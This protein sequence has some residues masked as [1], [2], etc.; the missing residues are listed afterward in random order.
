[1]KKI[2]SFKINK[3]ICRNK[4]QFITMN[5]SEM[6]TGQTTDEV[7][8]NFEPPTPNEESQEVQEVQNQ[9][10]F[11][12]GELKKFNLADAKIAELKEQYKDVTII[13]TNDKDGYKS[14]K[15]ALSVLRPIRTAIDKKRKELNEFPLQYQKAV[16]NEAKRLTELIEEIEKPIKERKD[17]IDGEKDRIKEAELKALEE[18]ANKRINELLT[19]GMKFEGEY[20]AIGDVNIS[21][22]DVRSMSDET[23]ATFLNAVKTEFKKTEDERL[24]KE[25]AD[26]LERERY[27]KEVAEQKAEKERLEKEKADLERQKTE[28][29]NRITDSRKNQ[30]ESIGMRYL[31]SERVFK[32]ENPLGVVTYNVDL[33]T[34]QTDAE[35]TQMFDG[36]KTQISDLVAKKQT[37]DAQAKE[38]AEKEAQE[39]AEKEAKDKAD[40]EEAE[41][42][43][44]LELA[45][46]LDKC[47]DAFD[48]IL[49][50]INA[51]KDLPIKDAE[52]K[53]S[54][55]DAINNI[56][57][58][59]NEYKNIFQN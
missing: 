59:I 57:L 9:E 12:K 39:K 21:V 36:L 1:M 34:L 10:E 27:E 46:D 43:R 16:N 55:F 58:A 3:Y 40:R 42:L 22:V 2:L 14:A 50:T 26:R 17:W 52:M 35:F 54:Y 13:D 45:P 53:K 48:S 56:E 11:L 30:L 41:R 29:Q 38:L 6:P 8:V 24:A 44:K 47:I 18:K 33:L 25:E 31:N 4:T 28:L 49:E 51:K 20:Y 37:A 19:N 32:Y 15:E 23:Y 5:Q 7:S